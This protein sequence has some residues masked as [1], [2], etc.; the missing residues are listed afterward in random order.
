LN[1]LIFVSLKIKQLI[2]RYISLSILLLATVFCLYSQT[3]E[4]NKNTKIG[5]HFFYYDAE[6]AQRIKATSLTD[7]LKNHNWNTPDNMQGGFGLDIMQGLTSHIDLVGTFNGSWANYLQPSG[8]YYGS[9]HFLLDAGAGLHLKLLPD[10]SVVSPF[11]ILKA[12][13]Q[14][15]M[16]LN[17]LSA[18]PG[19]GLQF[20]LF[21]EAFVIV[22]VAYRAEL[23]SVL[24]NHFYY[25]A[26][27]ATNITRPKKKAKVVT[28]EAPVIKEVP[29][30]VRDL[31]I[32]VHDEATGQ[33]LPYVEVT[34][35]GAEGRRLSGITDAAGEVVFKQM[36]AADFSVQ[37]ALN[38]IN[39]TTADIKALDFET[40]AQAVPVTLTHN[41]PRFTLSGIVI[42]KTK[43]QPEG[44]AGIQVSNLTKSSVTN[45]FSKEGDGMFLVQLEAGSDFS[46][47]AKKAD[48]ISNIEK[49]ST[50]GLNRSATLYV[51]LEL[52]IE[53]ARV[54]QSVVL[55]NIYFE[56]GKATIKADYSSDLDKLV[57]FLNDNPG[58][59]LEIQGHTDHTGSFALNRKLSQI[60]A[61]SVVKYLVSKGIASSRLTAKGYGPSVPLADNSTP[62][63]RQKNRRVEMKVIQ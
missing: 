29:K 11:L 14:K 21:G 24:S 51:K 62:E 50:K 19:I 40:P 5:L 8:T 49:I 26:G 4:N 31:R 60:R 13:Y 18:D 9:D 55:N 33:P 42:N 2:M 1:K 7:V 10:R 57:Q 37:G 38:N 28:P 17:G 54:G 63:G 27:F 58:S 45:K 47:V 48:Y 30:P 56:N 22:T 53:E 34:L 35:S 36:T 15:Y 59:R 3:I 52:G 32:M 41:D 20:S 6:T 16:E 44:G 25:S 61:E 39:T 46:V 12:S 23:N 43:N